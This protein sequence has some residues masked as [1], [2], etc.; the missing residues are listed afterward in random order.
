MNIEDVLC[1]IKGEMEESIETAM[2][3]GVQ[4]KHGLEAKKSLI[5]SSQLI[6]HIHEYIK[7]QLVQ[8]GI[9]AECVYPPLGHTKPELQLT[10]FLKQ[11]RQDI[12]VLPNHLQAVKQKV[13]WGPLSY[14]D[15][16]DVFGRELTEQILTINVRSQLSSV[17]KNADT[18]FERTY[19]ESSNFHELHKKMV[20]G[21]V[22][23]IPTHEYC[24]EAMLQNRVAWSETQ[25]NIEKYISFFSQISGREGEKDSPLKYEQCA[26]MIAD[27]RH[28]TPVLYRSLD[29]L[30]RDGLVS[31][32][33]EINKD[34]LSL[35][36]FV[37]NLLSIYHQRFNAMNLI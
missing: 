28:E 2:H 27:F 3:R 34:V 14:E 13:S 5:C 18:L 7:I 36:R 37:P 15:K 30:K 35:G 25:T 8:N 1:R 16:W 9:N 33:F 20:L 12:S 32:T 26:L 11:K 10:G 24:E 19:A 17:S 31:S 6:N 23:L 29:E 22:Y 21:E 4:K